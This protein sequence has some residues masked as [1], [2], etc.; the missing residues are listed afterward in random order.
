MPT[1]SWLTREKDVKS[2]DAVAYRLLE[3]DDALS[4]GET[5]SGNMLIQGDN[6]EAL[7][8]L[9]PYYRGQVKCIYIDPP[10]NTRSAFEHYD[11]NLEH[12]QWLAMIWPRLVLL[13]E[14]LAED[15]SIWVSI[16]DNEGHYLK[17]IMDE[18][19]GRRNFI[20]EVIWQKRTSRENRAAIGSAH[21]IVLVYSK[22]TAVEWKAVRNTLPPNMNGFSN[23]DGDA[24]GP[25]RSIPF[26][27]QGFRPNQ[28]YKITS[29]DG[30]VHEPPRGRCW[31]AT[32][33]VFRRYEAEGRV[34][35][36][37]GGAGKPRIKQFAGEEAGLVPMS[38]WL[39]E[40]VGTNEESKKEILALFEHDTPFGT[41]KPERLMERIV[42]IATNPGDLVLDSF[43]GSG[44]TAAVAHKM[45]RR[46][47]GVE[48]G[49]H[50]VTHCAPR[51]KKVVEGEQGGISQALGW[52][53]G[54]GFVF[55]RLGEAV[56]DDDGAINPGVSFAP[57]A[58]H[59]WF[60]ETGQPMSRPHSGPFLG[61]H[62]GNGYALLYNGI[63]GDKS[64]SGGNVLTRKTLDMI[65]ASAGEFVGPMTVYGEACRLSPETLKA[66]GI[67]FKQTPYDVRAR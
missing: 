22:R 62:G 48:M 39:A 64:V 40:E 15:G 35:F 30:T 20:A 37:K 55:Y 16:D 2:A 51:L 65:R 66:E 9:L 58:A 49:D 47:I 5:A 52:Q 43:L 54:G 26:S 42:R 50:A 53:G 23:P 24:R 7:K 21:D 33:E 14:L 31:G 63:L 46:W 44:T 8:S 67:V 34:Y 11:D 57:L 13:R 56:F 59:I 45:G 12:S 25:W 17:V 1:L 61:S 28:M 27:A 4:F 60:A 3:R 10:Y 19:F 6:L 41:P 18:V 36:P 38:L 29:T 32:E